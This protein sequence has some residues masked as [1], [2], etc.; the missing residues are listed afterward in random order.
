VIEGLALCQAPG[1]GSLG[2]LSRKNGAL[3]GGFLGG[4]DSV[5]RLRRMRDFLQSTN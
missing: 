4:S 3:K 5:V 2:P 1:L